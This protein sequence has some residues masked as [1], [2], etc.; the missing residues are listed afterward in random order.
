MLTPEGYYSYIFQLYLNDKGILYSVQFRFLYFDEENI[1][2]SL[3]N[4]ETFLQVMSSI[5]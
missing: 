2:E 5:V 4:D 3:N 1:E